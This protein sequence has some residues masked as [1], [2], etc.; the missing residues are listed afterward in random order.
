MLFKMNR[1]SLGEK[2]IFFSQ[3]ANGTEGVFQQL[4]YVEHGDIPSIHQN[5]V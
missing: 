2:G 3:T 4:D 5:K 1:T